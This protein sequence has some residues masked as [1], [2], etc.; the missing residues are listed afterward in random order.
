MTRN[1]GYKCPM[2]EASLPSL[3]R[4]LESAGVPAWMAWAGMSTFFVVLAFNV[5]NLTL[6]WLAAPRG[7]LRL[8]KE[9]VA[10]GDLQSLRS[11]RGTLG[12]S[13][14]A[15]I[16]NEELDRRAVL[17]AFACSGDIYHWWPRVLMAFGIVV[18]VV[19]PFLVYLRVTAV[20]S[21]IAKRIREALT[22]APA[23]DF[24]RESLGGA[25]ALGAF[26]LGWALASVVAALGF[27]LAVRLGLA[28]HQ[29][30]LVRTLG[31]ST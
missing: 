9:G 23:F 5:L 15:G 19:T 1:L 10:N 18:G 20:V 12:D 6:A 8:V 7:R 4:L 26:G 28:L 14:R 22:V 25:L 16:S 3:T 24:L 2:P 21:E 11:V 29:R 31:E 17:E 13:L 27:G 30:R